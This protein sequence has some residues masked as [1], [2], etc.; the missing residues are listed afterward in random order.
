[1]QNK[2]CNFDAIENIRS[3]AEAGLATARNQDEQIDNISTASSLF[4][5]ILREVEYVSDEFCLFE[6][7]KT[8][9]S[10]ELLKGN[11]N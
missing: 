6:Q 11:P 2:T 7:E 3:L 1:M 9:R 4:S 5:L 10:L 8:K